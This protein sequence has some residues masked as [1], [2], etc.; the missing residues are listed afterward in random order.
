M[1]ILTANNTALTPFTKLAAWREGHALVLLIYRVTKAFPREELFGLVSQIRRAAVSITS[2]IAE[3][4]SR[5]SY[6]EKIQFYAM[7]LGSLTELE[8]QLLVARDVGYLPP[9][10]FQTCAEQAILVGR[11]LKGLIKKSRTYVV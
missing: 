10:V 4:F 7:A 5:A 8:N 3:G 1:E 11:I 6:R 9:G 2:N